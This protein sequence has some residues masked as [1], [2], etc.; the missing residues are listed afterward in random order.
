[1]TSYIEVALT[2]AKGLGTNTILLKDIGREGGA[3]R[4][5]REKKRGK[6]SSVLTDF[7]HFCMVPDVFLV[8]RN[9]FFTFKNPEI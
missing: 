3:M 6:C 9:R 1:M 7:Y 2:L 5:R 8:L 4:R